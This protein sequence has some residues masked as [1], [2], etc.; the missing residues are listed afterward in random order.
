MSF[1]F[2]SEAVTAGHPD[3]LA[4]TISDAVLD[5][6]LAQDPRARVAVETFVTNGLCLVGGETRSNAVVEVA[7]VAREAI[8]AAGYGDPRCG[9][10]ADEVAVLVAMNRQSREIAMGVDRADGEQ[11]AGDQGLMFGYACRDTDV[12]MPLPIHLA[13]VLAR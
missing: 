4:D 7:E 1:L 11:G 9:Y 13:H 3:K 2:T 12:L 5:A 6:H 10:P 8:R